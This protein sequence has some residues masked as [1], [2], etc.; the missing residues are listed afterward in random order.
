MGEEDFLPLLEA[1]DGDGLVMRHDRPTGTWIL[2]ALHSSDL[3]RP[4][5][6]TRMRV[7]DSLRSAV[8]DAMRLAEGMTYKWAGLGM[9]YGGGKAV[10]A[11][12]RPLGPEE[13]QGLMRRYAKL[14]ESLS[15]A[16]FTG[17]DLGTTANDMAYLSQH[18]TCVLGV[19]PET[20]AATDPGPFTARGV[21]AGVRS[22]V[23][24]VLGHETLEN[25]RVLIQ[26]L[27]G[28]GIPLAH[29]LREEG[30]HLLLSDSQPERARQL[31]AKLGGEAVLASHVYSEECDVFS[32]CAVGGVL[33]EETIASLRCRIVAGSA[34]NQLREE[35][36]ADRLAKWGVTYVPD[37]IV[38][39]GGA[40]A[41]SL[42]R[43]GLQDR[44]QLM[45]RVD[46]IGQA[47]AD[48]LE[49]ASASAT[50][51]LA[52][53]RRRVDRLLSQTRG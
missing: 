41:I 53:A 17:A 21:L 50:T 15:Q 22:S 51:P 27:G 14:L 37:Y 9:Q 46:T 1:W 18:T 20:G 25:C 31:A 7:Y 19:D 45:E 38:N 12:T 5:G 26:G 24:L 49:E 13:R 52:S 33:S 47:V 6:G 11:I 3:G 29:L 43:E 40:M 48:I 4:T 8:R 30:A 23:R 2:I 36:D 39:A 10:M 35:D 34:N 16:F 32:P 42:M 28:V 44:D